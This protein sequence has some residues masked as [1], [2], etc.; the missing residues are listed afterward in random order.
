VGWLTRLLLLYSGRRPASGPAPGHPSISMWST[1]SNLQRQVI[2]APAGWAN[3]DRIGQ[4]PHRLRSTPTARWILYETALTSGQRPGDHAPYDT[5]ATAPTKFPHPASGSTTP[6]C[7]WAR[8]MSMAR[9]SLR[10]F[11]PRFSTYPRR[12]PNYPT[13]S[14]TAAAG[15]GALLPRRR[16]GGAFCP[17]IIGMIQ[18]DGNGE[19]HQPASAP[20]LSGRLLLF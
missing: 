6:A 11:R 7:C 3:Q 18:A 2:H 13:C 12:G 5:S 4:A 8:R 16:G 20:T 10:G 14:R 9:S 19:A 17:A 1:P 15:H